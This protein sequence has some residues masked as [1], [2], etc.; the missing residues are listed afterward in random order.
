MLTGLRGEDSGNYYMLDF[1]SANFS[2]K[3]YCKILPFGVAVI[4][5]VRSVK[6]GFCRRCWVVLVGMNNNH[7]VMVSI[8]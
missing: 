3:F 8:E 2:G 4:S 7:D 1:S 6:L 5:L